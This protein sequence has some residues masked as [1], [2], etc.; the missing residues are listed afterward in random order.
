MA[1]KDVFL[2]ELFTY[3][4]GA[5]ATAVVVEN[6][7]DERLERLSCY[8]SAAF[9]TAEILIVSGPRYPKD[10]ADLLDRVLAGVFLYELEPR[11]LL[12]FKKARKFFNI[13]FSISS[14]STCFF[15]L[16]IS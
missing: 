16:R 6:F 10:F 1:S 12:C 2:L 8:F 14:S 15:S 11:E 9:F 7:L 4:P 3:P 5:I 13:S